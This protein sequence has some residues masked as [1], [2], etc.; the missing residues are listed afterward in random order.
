[1]SGAV[2]G[3]VIVP[4]LQLHVKT[5]MTCIRSVSIHGNGVLVKRPTDTSVKLMLI[6]SRVGDDPKTNYFEFEIGWLL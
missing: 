3:G 4:K 6:G 1:M 2:L 5:C